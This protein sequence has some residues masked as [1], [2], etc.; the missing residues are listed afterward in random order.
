MSVRE[1]AMSGMVSGLAGARV[2]ER[3]PLKT[4]T[5]AQAPMVLAS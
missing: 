2:A 4:E 1:P 5:Q 3:R